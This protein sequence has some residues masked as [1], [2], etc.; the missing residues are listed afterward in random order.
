MLVRLGLETTHHH[1]PADEDRLAALTISSIHEYRSFLVRVLGFEAP[2]EE[3][4]AKVHQI[5]LRFVRERARVPLLRRDLLALGMSERD[6]GECPRATVTIRTAPEAL[7]WMFVLERQTLLAGLLRR[8]IQ[9]VLGTNTP[10]MYLNAYG[11][12]PGARM[13][14]FGTRL[15]ELAHT[16]SPSAIIDA[17]NIAFRSQRQWYQ[18][19]DAADQVLPTGVG[20]LSASA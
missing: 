17:A 15:G 7:G 9:Q 16:Q 3:A 4:V 10:T 19:K 2:V 1:A 8:Q 11:G 14:D 18:Q 12:A 13:R 5:E 20:Q 6:I